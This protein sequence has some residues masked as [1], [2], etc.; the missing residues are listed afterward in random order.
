MPEITPF[1]IRW[2]EIKAIV[3]ATKALYDVRVLGLRNIPREGPAIVAIN[4]QSWIDPPF[5]SSTIGIERRRVTSFFVAAN[6]LSNP[7]VRLVHEQSASIPVERG[8][9]NLEV[10][11]L[12]KEVLDDG[13]MLGIFP[14]GTRSEDG[15]IG[16]GKQGLGLI[17]LQTGVPVIPTAITGAYD[18]WPK[19]Q[20]LPKTGGKI[21]L[22]FGEPM[23]FDVVEDPTKEQALAATKKVMDRIREMARLEGYRD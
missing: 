8:S 16:D 4:H 14:E 17:A 21:V 3:A 1:D 11:R 20:K 10:V 2:L 12:A 13:R 22:R 15:K 7:F 19:G 18:A 5:I 23:T 9:G 6:Y